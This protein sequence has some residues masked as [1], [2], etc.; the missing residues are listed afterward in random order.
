MLTCDFVYF[1]EALKYSIVLKYANINV[2]I[3][4]NPKV[5]IYSKV[6]TGDIYYSPCCH[7]SVWNLV[8]AEKASVK[9][10]I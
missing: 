2:K 9:S 10:S 1:E 8:F 5:N 3:E 6:P 7:V 4:L